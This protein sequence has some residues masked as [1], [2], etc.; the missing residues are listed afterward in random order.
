MQQEHAEHT[1]ETIR[2]LMERSQRYE[3]ISGLGGLIAGG[4]ACAGGAVLAA[5]WLSWSPAGSFGVVWSAVFVVALV[6]Q[7]VLTFARARQRR[8]SVWSR[9][10]RTVALALLPCLVAGMT[11]T[12]LMARIGQLDWLPAVW[13][14]LYGTGALATSFFA[15]RSIGRLGIACLVLGAGALLL[16]VPY[17]VLTMVV[18]FGLTHLIYGGAV[19]LAER[20]HAREQAFWSEVQC[21]ANSENLT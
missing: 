12:V 15:P 20:R 16:P 10:A 6:S 4:A 9:Q 5:G 1:L 8:E 19:L 18:G 14:L 13:L 11:V 3:H 2:T 7:C 21:M 17:P